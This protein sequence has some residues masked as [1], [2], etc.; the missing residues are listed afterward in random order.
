MTP[1]RK[2]IVTPE[3]YFKIAFGCSNRQFY[4][5]KQELHEIATEIGIEIEDGYIEEKCDYEGDLEEIRIDRVRDEDGSFVEAILKYYRVED[6]IP[7]NM[8]IVLSIF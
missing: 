6:E 7:E 3:P 2:E 5:V 1:N 4:E 8:D